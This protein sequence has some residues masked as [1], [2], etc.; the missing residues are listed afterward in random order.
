MPVESSISDRTGHGD[1]EAM[2]KSRIHAFSSH[3]QYYGRVGVGTWVR[4]S[5][6]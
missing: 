3:G 4:R 2:D 1:A 6:D 5:P